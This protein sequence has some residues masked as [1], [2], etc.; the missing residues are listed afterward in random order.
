M[1]HTHKIT[2]LSSY[3]GLYGTFIESSSLPSYVK[4]IPKQRYSIENRNRIYINNNGSNDTLYIRA[5]V[6][7]PRFDE[8][9]VSN[10]CDAYMDFSFQDWGIPSDKTVTSIRTVYFCR[11]TTEYVKSYKNTG[12]GIGLQQVNGGRHTPGRNRRNLYV[13]QP[14]ELSCG[15]LELRQ[16]DNTLIT[17]LAP[18]SYCGYIEG[19]GVGALNYY[20]RKVQ[21]LNPSA[22]LNPSNSVLDGAKNWIHVIGDTKTVSLSA[23]ETYRLYIKSTF[24]RTDLMSVE[25]TAVNPSTCGKG[26]LLRIKSIMLFMEYS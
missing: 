25:Q 1:T 2:N 26:I 12:T 10:N 19:N 21:Q 8:T 7:N 5:S 3:D 20:P 14:N 11:W 22:G 15:P 23:I 17:E 16:T 24:P 18:I 4:I 13:A 9:S 6:G